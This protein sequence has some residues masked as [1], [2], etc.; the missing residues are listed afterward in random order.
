MT[1]LNEWI[2]PKLKKLFIIY[3]SL[4]KF[5]DVNI[6]RSCS[7]QN[8][9]IFIRSFELASFIVSSLLFR[10]FPPTLYLVLMCISN[11]ACLDFRIWSKLKDKHSESGIFLSIL[12]SVLIELLAYLCWK[13]EQA[14]YCLILDSITISVNYLNRL[15]I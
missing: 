12:I 14:V 10:M 9:V 15:Q 6:L 13:K 8:L 3:L 2:W 4:L 1:N 5:V 11:L 7:N